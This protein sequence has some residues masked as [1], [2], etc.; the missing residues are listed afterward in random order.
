MCVYRG[1]VKHR[2]EHSASRARSEIIR[3]RHISTVFPVQPVPRLPPSFR[4]W[5]YS[6][7]NIQLN[8]ESVNIESRN[9][10]T[11]ESVGWLD[12]RGLSSPLFNPSFYLSFLSLF[13]ERERDRIVANKYRSRVDERANLRRV[14]RIYQ[15]P[16]AWNKKKEERNDE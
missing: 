5:F 11:D 1:G 14:T 15:K 13:F 4:P 16:S 6:P 12:E 9:G 2:R 7:K 10:S 3:T 8:G